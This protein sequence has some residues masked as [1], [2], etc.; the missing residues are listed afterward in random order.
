MNNKMFKVGDLVQVKSMRLL[1]K[2]FET[3]HQFQTQLDAMSI[4][5]IESA[6][7]NNMIYLEGFRDSFNADDFQ[8]M[9]YMDVI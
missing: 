4:Y 7:G 1:D 2:W 8:H 3:E 6:Y 5:T 9:D